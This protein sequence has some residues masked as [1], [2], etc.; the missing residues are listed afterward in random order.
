MEPYKTSRQW[1]G[2]GIGA[3]MLA[4]FLSFVLVIGRAP[5]IHHLITDPQFARRCL[6]IHV[7]LALFV[8]LSAVLASLYTL[9]PGYR[10]KRGGTL[11]PPHLAMM[12]IA[13]FIISGMFPAAEPI[14]SNYIPV[15]DHPLF[16]IGMGLVLLALVVTYL[17]A[18]PFRVRAIVDRDHPILP[19]SVQHGLRWTAIA[20][21][22]AVM[23]LIITW[24]RLSNQL[25]AA[26]YYDYLFW[27]AGHVLQSVNVMG[28]VNVWLILFS[29]L[30]GR[31]WLSLRLTNSLF[32]LLWLPLLYA[33]YIAYHA[34]N[35]GFYYSQF[36]RLM[37][38][39]IFPGVLGFLFVMGY[40]YFRRVSAADRRLFWQQTPALGFLA[41]ITLILTGFLLGAFIR[42]SNTLVPAHYHAAI[43]SITVIYMVM[44]YQL[45]PFF[46]FPVLS[47]LLQRMASWQPVVFG[48]GQT[49]FAVG[50]AMAGLTRKVYGAEQQIHTLKEYVGMGLMGLGGLMAIAGGILFIW[51]VTTAVSP[52]V[53]LFI[54]KKRRALWKAIKS[55]PFRS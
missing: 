46:G 21:L 23:T 17:Q 49:I 25:D 3:L 11:E 1:L 2:I 20:F 34:P 9:L 5:L 24:W 42:T 16:F 30:P 7:N 26:F 55:I 36:T 19:V 12:G 10:S 27:G 41:S 31:P 44:V 32:A 13:L 45:L 15:L 33:P 53:P 40:A 37:Q 48:F 50:F 43:G 52:A 54:I 18:H 14:M 38:F 29:R 28:M 8:W 22:L 6:V 51:I 47:R 39:G 35:T 4:G